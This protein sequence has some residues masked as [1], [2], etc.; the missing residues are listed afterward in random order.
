MIKNLSQF[1]KA[2]V[3]GSKWHCFHYGFSSEHEAKDMGIR[4]V[5][6]KQTNSVAFKTIRTDGTECDSWHGFGKASQYTFENGKVQVLNKCAGNNKVLM[7]YEL[8]KEE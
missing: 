3:I 1:K 6:I 7:E 4:P 2:L 5:S 8:I